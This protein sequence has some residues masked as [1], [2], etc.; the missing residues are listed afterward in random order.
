MA[1]FFIFSVRVAAKWRSKEM[2]MNVIRIYAK[3]FHSLSNYS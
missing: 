3:S 1:I 2:F